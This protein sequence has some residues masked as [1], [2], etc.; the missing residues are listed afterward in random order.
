MKGADFQCKMRN[1][2]GSTDQ[3]TVPRVEY[4]N[5]VANTV[6]LVLEKGKPF[7]WRAQVVQ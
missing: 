4:I 1:L 2:S 5:E 6:S 3:E 7:P